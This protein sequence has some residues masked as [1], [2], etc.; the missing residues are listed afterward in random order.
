MTIRD[1]IAKALCCEHQCSYPETCQSREL[2]GD[3]TKVVIEMLRA[4]PPDD[5]TIERMAKAGLE[6]AGFKRPDKTQMSDL[7]IVMHAAFAAIWEE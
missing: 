3:D 2:Y 5:A 1:T 4:T 7:K 6:K